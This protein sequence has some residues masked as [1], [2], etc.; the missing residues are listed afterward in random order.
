MAD[1]LKV[2]QSIPGYDNT[3]KNPAS[4]TLQ[5]QQGI[6]NVVNPDRVTKTDSKNE[7]SQDSFL[8]ASN[9]NFNQFIQNMTAN[10]SAMEAFT[11]LFQSGEAVSVSSGIGE[12]FAQEISQFLE[13]VSMDTEG[14]LASFLKDQFS[15]QN[16]FTGSFFQTMFQVLDHTSSVELKSMILEFARKANDMMSEEHIFQNMDTLLGKIQNSMFPADSEKL[17][18]MAGQLQQGAVD[19]NL[20]QL[21]QQVIPFL[22]QYITKTNDFG[23]IRNLIT[24]LTLNVSRYENGKQDGVV[25]SFQKV[26]NFREFGGKL[27]TISADQLVAILQREAKSN[28][29]WAEKFTGMME[30][31]MKGTYGAENKMVF[32][33]LMNSLL[34]NESVYMPLMHMMIPV[35]YQNH[36]MFSELWIDPDSQ[37]NQG[38]GKNGGQ[39]RQL[40][41]LI[42]FDI[43]GVG[44]FDLVF[45]Y[46]EDAMSI[47]LYYPETLKSEEKEIQKKLASILADNGLKAEDIQLGSREVP[48]TL[49]EVF[50]KIYEGRNSVNVRV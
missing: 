27:G 21:K 3:V 20:S 6:Q 43:Q 42:K 46:Q 49:T 31:S 35:N 19:Q 10:P 39:G 24:L 38:N 18:Q 28:P 9:S 45:R 5:Q 13:M 1:I 12:N 7:Y 22:H 36:M 17:N 44:Y 33:N 29:T 11:R 47:S 4:P 30:E 41:G 23:K 16:G 2:T 37:E 32:Q 15:S 48:L 26:L 34:M 50:P 25:Q 8:L 40:K 14:A